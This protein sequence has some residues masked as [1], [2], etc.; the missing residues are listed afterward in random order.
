MFEKL[1]RAVDNDNAL[2]NYSVDLKDK[3]GGYTFAWNQFID[4]KVALMNK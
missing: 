2:S 4:D 1:R 3:V